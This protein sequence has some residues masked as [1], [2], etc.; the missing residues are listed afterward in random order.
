VN[1]IGRSSVH[2]PPRSPH[3]AQVSLV[4]R[5]NNDHVECVAEFMCG[6]TWRC[7]RVLILSPLKPSIESRLRRVGTQRT[8]YSGTYSCTL[9][10]IEQSFGRSPQFRNQSSDVGAHVRSD[11][12]RILSRH[13]RLMIMLWFN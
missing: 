4:L 10:E 3:L 5:T 11:S 12:S 9:C 7:N 1:R 8:R 6:L 2:S 13:M